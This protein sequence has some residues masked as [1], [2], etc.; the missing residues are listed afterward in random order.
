MGLRPQ[1]IHPSRLQ[2]AFPRCFVH[3][4]DEPARITN[5][6]KPEQQWLLGKFLQPSVVRKLR[7]AKAEFVE[8]PGV[9]IDECRHAKFLCKSAELTWR[10]WALH[11]IDEVSLDAALGEKTQRFTRIRAFFDTEYLYFQLLSRLPEK[12]IEVNPVPSDVT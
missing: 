6:W 1:A 9:S 5:Q 11:E 8:T 3:A 12:C 2:P 10:C 4:D 7:I